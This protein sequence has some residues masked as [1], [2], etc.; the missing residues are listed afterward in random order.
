MDGSAK[1]VDLEIVVGNQGRVIGVSARGNG[2]SGMKRCCESIVRS[3]KFP[4]SSSPQ[5]A[6]SWWFEVDY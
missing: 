5:T 3:V 6:A 2:S 1:R 4:T